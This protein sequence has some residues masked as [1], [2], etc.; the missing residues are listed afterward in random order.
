MAPTQPAAIAAIVFL[1]L[2]SLCRV[3]TASAASSALGLIKEAYT[4][5][6]ICGKKNCINPIF[7]GMEDLHQLS[8]SP[9]IASSLQKTSEHMGFCRSAISYDPALPVP[10][11][12]SASV[13]DLVQRQDNAASTMFYY[14]LNGLGYEAW[15]YQQPEFADDCI[16]SIWRMVCFTYFPRAEIGVQDG[17]WSK[18]MRPCQSSCQNYIRTCGVECCDESVQCVFSHEKA[19]T[20]GTIVTSQGYVPH[21]GPSAMCTGGASRSAKPFGGVF[22]AV[23]LLVISL[24]L[25]GC[26]MDIPLHKVGNWRGETDYLI[27]NAHITPGASAQTAILNSCSMTTLAQSQQCSGRGTCQ[28]WNKDD[29]NS[30]LTFCE[31]DLR[32]VDPECKTRRK[33]QAVAYFLALFFGFLGLD[34]FYLGFMAM[35]VL[36]LCSLGGFGVL[37]ILDVIK[38]GSAPVYSSNYR[39]AADL[40][41]FVFVLSTAASAMFWGFVIAYVMVILFRFQRRKESLLMQVDEERRSWAATVAQKT[42]AIEAGNFIP[43]GSMPPAMGPP[44]M[45]QMPFMGQAGPMMPPSGPM[46]PPMM[47]GSGMMNPF[48]PPSVRL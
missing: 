9:W 2:G 45:G 19:I 23:I 22:W 39:V 13:K 7:P 18:Y 6:A 36:K 10:Q 33:S 25:Q 44:T 21:D 48:G 14:H 27:K 40:P 12:G 24:S 42:G 17:A 20:G 34:Q 4:T 41:H 28:L 31:C 35:G 11:G 16:K 38:I 46:M 3:A 43:Y 29:I 8:L 5:N 30:E 15:D 32:W 37:Y 1:G 26:N 47:P